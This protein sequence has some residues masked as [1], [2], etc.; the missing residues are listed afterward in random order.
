MLKSFVMLSIE[1]LGAVGEI[2][3]LPMASP[4]AFDNGL[5][6]K[7][8]NFK[9]DGSPRLVSVGAPGALAP[10]AVVRLRGVSGVKVVCGAGGSAGVFPKL[11]M[12][13]TTDAADT[14]ADAGIA[15]VLLLGGAAAIPDTI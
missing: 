5:V 4:F 12:P 6:R 14:G 7:E 8:D 3:P 11:C 15:N 10:F 1:S 2:D 9:V 13:A